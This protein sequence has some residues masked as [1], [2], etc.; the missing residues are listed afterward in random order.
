MV[1]YKAIYSYISLCPLNDSKVDTKQ[2]CKAGQLALAQHNI[3]TTASSQ[4]SKPT[5]PSY[6]QVIIDITEYVFH[7]DVQ[8]P[9]AWSYARTAVLD[10]LGCAIETVS[11]SAECRSFLGPVVADTVVPDGFRLPGT[12]YQLDPLKGAFDLGTMIRYLDHNDALAG[13]DWGH[14]SGE[15]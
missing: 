7:Y 9:R 14:P 13:A 1:V 3:M 5:F 15:I 11:K 6:D 4:A 12:S 10:A 2:T 8:S